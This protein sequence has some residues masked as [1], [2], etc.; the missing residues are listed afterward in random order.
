ME[1]PLDADYKNENLRIKPEYRTLIYEVDESLE[2]I[3]KKLSGI[4]TTDEDDS[5]EVPN[6][7]ISDESQI[8]SEDMDKRAIADETSNINQDIDQLDTLHETEN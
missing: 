1:N 7:S 3:E 2:E 6:D 8:S 4:Q 5:N